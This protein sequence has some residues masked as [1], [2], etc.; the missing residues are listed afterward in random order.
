MAIALAGTVL[1][2]YLTW[3]H[4]DAG[5]LVCGIGDCHTVQA[6]EFATVGPVPVALLGLGMYLTVLVCNLAARAR[7][8]LEFAALS[9][10]FASALGGVV[11]AIYLTWLEVAVIGAICQWCVVSA[12]LTALLAGCQGWAVWRSLAIP[13]DGAGETDGP[14]AASLEVGP[15]GKGPVGLA[16]NRPRAVR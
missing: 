11:F 2:G 5:A 6:S 8:P 7:P 10:A 13:A 16:G 4:F 15:S 1:A 14:Y 3:T 12:I 9:I